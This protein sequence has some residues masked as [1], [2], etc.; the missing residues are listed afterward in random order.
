MPSGF[1]AMA[2][3]IQILVLITKKGPWERDYSWRREISSLASTTVNLRYSGNITKERLNRK[4]DKPFP[5]N[6]P[7][8]F[9]RAHWSVSVACNEYPRTPCQ[10]PQK[11][12]FQSTLFLPQS[13][14]SPA[15]D[16][17]SQNPKWGLPGNADNLEQLWMVSQSPWAQLPELCSTGG[18]GKVLR[19]FGVFSPIPNKVS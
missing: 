2:L 8:L 3:N 11:L 15:R 1:L 19:A 7:P 17:T 6:P 18:P 4:M 14:L 5:P 9:I 13:S 10:T 16:K 12:R